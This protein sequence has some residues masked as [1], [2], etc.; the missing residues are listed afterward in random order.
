[1][2][3]PKVSGTWKY[4]MAMGISAHYSLFTL[5]SSENTDITYG[6][7]VLLMLSNILLTLERYCVA[8]TQPAAA[9]K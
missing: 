2:N 7:Q 9:A 4:D 1:M 6:D 5:R 3:S 8:Y